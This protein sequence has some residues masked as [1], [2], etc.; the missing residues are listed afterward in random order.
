MVYANIAVLAVSALLAVVCGYL[1]WKCR[2]FNEEALRKESLLR[3]NGVYVE[4]AANGQENMRDSVRGNAATI[5]AFMNAAYYSCDNF[6]KYR[7]NIALKFEELYNNGR[8]RE[9]TRNIVVMANMAENGAFYTL[10]SDF[11]LTDIELRTCCFIY[12]GFKWQETCT[13]ES[14]TENA[15]NV[16]CSRIRKKLGMEKEEKI[17]EFIENYCRSKVTANSSGQ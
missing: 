15:Y 4:V 16:R 8:L 1:Y 7:N 5:A 9:L 11:S 13:A 6:E 10:A 12:F 14:I 2:K 3:K 17:P